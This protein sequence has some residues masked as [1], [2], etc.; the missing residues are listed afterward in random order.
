MSQEEYDKIDISKYLV[1]LEE[2]GCPITNIVMVSL[3]LADEIK[4]ILNRKEKLRS[5]NDQFHI[6]ET[7]PTHSA[8]IWMW[9]ISLLSAAWTEWSFTARTNN[10]KYQNDPSHPKALEN[11]RIALPYIRPSII[12]ALSKGKEIGTMDTYDDKTAFRPESGPAWIYLR[13]E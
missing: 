7:S 4:N 9:V 5:K 6:L 2:T 3:H 13:K 10:P 8:E 1:R 11:V 12:D